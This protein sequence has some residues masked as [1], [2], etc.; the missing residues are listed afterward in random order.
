MKVQLGQTTYRTRIRNILSPSSSM[1]PPLIYQKI[2]RLK[3]HGMLTLNI[4][5]LATKAYQYTDANKTLITEFVGNQVGNYSHVLKSPHPFLCNLHGLVDDQSSWIFTASELNNLK[6]DL[7]YQNFIRACLSAKTI[8]FVGISAD[9]IAVGGFLKDLS[10]LEIDIGEHYW[11]THRRDQ[12]TNR[13]A[14]RNGVRLI[15]YQALYGEHG[16]LLEAMDDLVKFIS[17]DDTT[18]LGPIIPQGMDPTDQALPS[19]EELLRLDAESIREALNREATRL[20]ESSGQ[21]RNETYLKFSNT[22]DEAIYRAWYTGPETGKTKF[23]G[24]TLNEEVASGSFGKVYRASDPDGNG[25]AIKILHQDMRRNKDLFLAFRR[26]VRSMQILGD[27]GVEGMVPYRKAFE[28]PAFVV[29]DWIDG[30]TLGDAVAAKQIEDWDL[31]LK[32]GSAVADIV[33]QGHMLPERVLHRDLRPSNIMLRGFYSDPQ[34]WEVVVLDFDLSWHRGALEQSV[35][36]GSALLGYLA[37]EQIQAMPGISTRHATVDSFGLGM[38]LFFMLSGRDPVPDQ[39]RHVDWDT[40]LFEAAYR[41]PFLQWVSVPR[42]FSRLVHFA[43]MAD[44]SERW[45]MTQIQAELQRLQAVVLDPSY[46]AS[47]ELVAEELAAR[48]EFSKDY[49]WN[50]NLLAA[51][52][53]ESSGVKLSIQETNR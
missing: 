12:E 27:N 2:W 38:V 7:G 5:R 16:D 33:R 21:D 19:Q 11:F 13:W 26:G 51:E 4:D 50:A 14:E 37:P 31:I 44:Q 25:V 48:C 15:N 3:P 35:T 40:T 10:N 18:D 45:D 39:H 34:D 6:S 32:I 30:P 43:T 22:Y 24:Y 49:S 28:I 46:S 41:R 36:H 29:M 47:P 23:L 42:R 52:K 53:E 8:V 9:D 17:V 20:L 1:E